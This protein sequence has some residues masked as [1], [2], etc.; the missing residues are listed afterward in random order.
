MIRVRLNSLFF[1]MGF[2]L[3]FVSLGYSQSIPQQIN[4]NGTLADVNG[5]PVPDGQYDV[6]FTIYD[7]MTNGNVLWTET[8]NSSTAQVIVTNGIF[9][10]LLGAHNTIQRSFFTDHPTAYLGVKVGTDA[11]MLPRQGVGVQ[12]G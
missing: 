2:L 10:A 4:Y 7:A 11:E 6:V 8:W 1:M 5:N 12:L 9:N 3:C